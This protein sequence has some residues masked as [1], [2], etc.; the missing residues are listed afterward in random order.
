MSYK[1]EFIFGVLFLIILIVSNQVCVGFENPNILEEDSGE[2][3]PESLYG[4][5]REDVETLEKPK[6]LGYIVQFDEEPVMRKKLE[7]EEVA[8]KNQRYIDERSSI[9]PMRILYSN[10]A[11]TPEKVGGEL[12]E[13]SNK[14]EDQHEDIKNRIINKLEEEEKNIF[15]GRIINIITGKSVEKSNEEDH[16]EIKITN[17]FKF[18]FN[19]IALNISD[20]EAKEIEDI[21]GVKKVWPNRE[22]EALLMDSVPLIQEGISAG[23]LD[24]DGNDCLVTGKECLTGEGIKIAIIDTGVD[25][26]HPD[27]GNCTSEEFLEGNCEKVIGGYDFINYDEDP[28]DDQGHGTHVAATAAGNGEGGL[29]GVAPNAKVLSYKVLSSE[30]FG[31]N[32]GVIAGIEQ[33]VIGGADILSLSLGGWGDP[34]DPGSQAVDSAVLSGKVVVVAAG[35][36]GPSEQT[37]GSPGTARKVITVG[38]TNNINKEDRV[39]GFSSRGPVIWKDG[40]GNKKIINKPDIL[41]PGVNICAAQYDSAWED[42]QCLDEKHTSISGTSMATPHVAGVIALLKQKHP[43]WTPEE[44]KAS[45]KGTA[46][47]LDYSAIKQGAGRINVSALVKLEVPYPLVEP[48]VSYGEKE[49]NISSDFYSSEGL[50]YVKLYLNEELLVELD[51]P[52]KTSFSYNLD[53]SNYLDGDYFAT[54]EAKSKNEKISVE[55]DI[56]IQIENFVISSL[57]SYDVYRT[58]SIIDINLDKIVRSDFDCNIFYSLQNEKNWVPANFIE[59]LDPETGLIGFLNTSSLKDGVYEFKIVFDIP[60]VGS[61]EKEVEK[62]YFDSS[63]KEG[64]PQR[65]EDDYVC[66]N[67]ANVNLNYLTSKDGN[68][69]FKAFQNDLDPRYF[70]GFNP[71]LIYFN[72]NVLNKSSFYSILSGGQVSQMNNCRYYSVGYIEPVVEDL[73][74]NGDK[75]IVIYKGGAPPK[76]VVYDVNGN[77]NWEKKVGDQP[78]PGGNLHIP[79]V[80]DLDKDDNKEIIVFS[81]EDT[82]SGISSQISAFKHDGT[83]FW[84]T[85]I[86]PHLMVTMLMADLN[87]DG[88]NEI[89]IK[90]NSGSER[91]I[92]ILSPKGEIISLIDLHKTSWGAAIE[93]S[94]AV[95]NFDNDLDLE[96]VNADPSEGAGG[97]YDDEHINNTGRIDVFNLD[98]TYVDGWPVFTEGV[99]FSSPV[100][101][102]LNNDGEDNLLVGLMYG[103][104][105]WPD[106]DY[107]GVYA[108][109][110]NG[111]ILE[112]WP[113]ERGYEFW[114]SPALGDISKDEGL[115]VVISSLSGKTYLFN[116]SGAILENWPQSTSGLSFYSNHLVDI[117]NDRNLNVLTRAGSNQ[118]GG[119]VYVWDLNGNILEGFPKTI[120][121]G[122]APLAI[123]EDNGKIN[124]ATSSCWDGSEY[125]NKFRGS[126][127]VWKLDASYNSD[128]MDWPLFQYDNQNTGRYN[129]SLESPVLNNPP[130]ITS[131]PITDINEGE[132]YSYLVEAV[133]DDGD[134]LEYSLNESPDW[135]SIN[136]TTGLIEGTAP[137]IDEDTGSDV[138]PNVKFDVTI[139]VYD[140][141]NYTEQSYTLIVFK[142]STLIRG[143]IG[144]WKVEKVDR[145]LNTEDCTLGGTCNSFVVNYSNSVLKVQEVS[146]LLEEYSSLNLNEEEFLESF[147]DSFGIVLSETRIIDGKYYFYKDL[148]RDKE[149]SVSLISWYSDNKM[150]LIVAHW[151]KEFYSKITETYFS[152]YPSKLIVKPDILDTFDGDT[153]DINEIKKE[154]IKGL[155]LEKKNQGKIVFKDSVNIS[156]F[157]KNTK[158]LTDNVDITSKKI[159]INTKSL[160]RLKNSKA[161][162]TFKEIDFKQPI[163][164]HN[165]EN[166]SDEVC[167]DMKYL[168]ST[169]TLTLNISGFSTFEVVEGYEE[170][171]EETTNPSDEEEPEETTN[172]SDEEE[173]KE[174][175]KEEP[176]DSGTTGHGTCTPEWECDNWEICI[177][178]SQERD[179][180]DVNECG[181]YTGKPET[182]RDCI[183]AVEINTENEDP[184]NLDQDPSFLKMYEE[185]NRPKIFFVLI[186]IWVVLI[187]IGMI[188]IFKHMKSNTKR[189]RRGRS[190][191]GSK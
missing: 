58:G 97:V 67:F 188:S 61:F 21:K 25:Y 138:E 119:G 133:D 48:I 22:V 156:G 59:Q 161:V 155:I 150:V 54:L 178:G 39:A 152:R 168:N 70:D 171:P 49:I 5:N 174:E 145:L 6:S 140:R 125:K 103:S 94:L 82:T 129:K 72:K 93:S 118:N 27:L 124:I 132:A 147:E 108:F 114:S 24:E 130:E 12:E 45:I 63:L 182:K 86:P 180:E 116:P 122:I 28:I 14:I 121:Q 135:V 99:V 62:V 158:L 71:E 11:I 83:L 190:K 163:V 9:S 55:K 144:K 31:N 101:G 106:E 189:I 17:E 181:T 29:K 128:K 166:C 20:E 187:L 34:D 151:D 51:N 185:E 146:V 142:E 173:P 64:W 18:S 53:I 91:K 186:A 26:T 73:D 112:G 123:Y 44:I 141:I 175:P 66:E 52:D 40:E 92:I 74:N 160:P 105:S 43:D 85:E 32:A 100:V 170:E 84:E 139:R 16:E 76:I 65:V 37:I 19:G 41:A 78:I 127:Y 134:D 136:S 137:M 57:Q 75:E 69:L 109:D 104:D 7:V 179:C 191:K 81:Y 87:N 183:A 172:P 4:E 42:S 1:R 165:G 30:G 96:I 176:T 79:L 90:G 164:L 110:R 167:L 2:L 38:A 46:I 10:F 47:D 8:E 60:G 177:N 149:D 89:V 120:E 162:L 56:P 184:Q 35:N 159:S 113:V 117:N 98:G 88:V 102:D 50:S 36:S 131:S 154:S 68:I 15:T 115:E 95:G 126:V 13:Y 148:E 169:N 107:G 3:S 77:I 23:Q 80:G 33:A 111:N 143:D 157:K 153:T